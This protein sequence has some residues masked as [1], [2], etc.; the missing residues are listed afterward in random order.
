MDGFDIQS[1]L[2]LE[3]RIGRKFNMIFVDINGSRDIPTLWACVD[4]LEKSMRPKMMVIK[5][6]KVRMMLRQ[7]EAFEMEEGVDPGATSPRVPSTKS[8]RADARN[9]AGSG[10]EESGTW[11]AADRQA[12][13]EAEQEPENLCPACGVVVERS[14]LVGAGGGVGWAT[15]ISAGLV[16]FAGGFCLGRASGR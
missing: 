10:A 6:V 12:G 5:S 14:G 9:E 13:V 4:K 7:C 15:F 8:A 3:K 1:I 16:L 2:K 11:A